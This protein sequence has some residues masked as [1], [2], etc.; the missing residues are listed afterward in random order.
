MELPVEDL[1]FGLPR[2]KVTMKP[3]MPTMLK[4]TAEDFDKQERLEIARVHIGSFGVW[5]V[6]GLSHNRSLYAMKKGGKVAVAK[7]VTVERGLRSR[8]GQRHARHLRPRHRE[9]PAHPL[10][11]R[12]PGRSP[13]RGRR[14][15]R[16]RR[17]KR[18]RKRVLAATK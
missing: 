18:R 15:E 4:W 10:M 13:R 5:V 1:H 17:R 11:V 8:R 6:Q 3:T 12:A 2:C 16:R 14:G 7:C 9:D